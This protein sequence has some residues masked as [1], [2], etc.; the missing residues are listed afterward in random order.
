MKYLKLILKIKKKQIDTI[1]K[2][3]IICIKLINKIFDSSSENECEMINNAIDIENIMLALPNHN[4]DLSERNVFI[5]LARK[6]L[7]DISYCEE[8]E[9]YYTSFIINK[10]YNLSQIIN[11]GLISNFNYHKKIEFQRS[12]KLR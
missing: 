7:I 12:N 2:R 11:N 9:N 3:F 6:K 1:N 4:L 5:R 10:K 8:K